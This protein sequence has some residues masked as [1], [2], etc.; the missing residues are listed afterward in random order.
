MST[1]KRILLTG[2]SRGLGRAMLEGFIEA[3][4]RVCAC[5]RDAQAVERLRREFAAPHQFA[6][7]DVADDAAVGA[8]AAAVEAQHDPFDLV[9]NNAAVVNRLAPLWEQSAEEM[10]AIFAINVL[11]TVHVIRHFV[12]AM[13]RR[14]SGVI[15]NFSSGW[16]RSTAPEVAPYCGTKYAIEGLTLALAEELPKSMAAVPLNPGVINTDMLQSCFGAGAGNYPSPEQWA[17]KAVPMI[18]DLG[19]RDNGQSLSVDA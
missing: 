5:S 16:G 4:H 11:G 9:V 10:A 18:L 8:W 3:G 15:V 19:A 6:V 2:A 12:P 1:S 14:G 17:K 7:V 13:V